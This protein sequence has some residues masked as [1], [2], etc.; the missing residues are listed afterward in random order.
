MPEIVLQP[1]A[2]AG[3]DTYINE[4]SAANNFGTNIA[5]KVGFIGNNNQDGH[6]KF[7]LSAIAKGSKIQEAILSLYVHGNISLSFDRTIARVLPANIDWTE[8]GA[9]WNLLDGANPW[10]GGAGGEEAGV[11]YDAGLLFNDAGPWVNAAFNDFSL[12]A[13]GVQ[14]MVDSGNAGFKV[15]STTRA[16]G[17]NRQVDISSSDHGTAGQRPKL[18]VRWI[19]PSGRLFEYKV[20]KF[21]A[22]PTVLDPTG[23]E[24][25]LNEVRPDKW[26]FIEGFDLPSGV[27]YDSLIPDPRMSYGVGVTFDEDGNKLAVE[28]DRN[29][30]ADAIIQRLTRGV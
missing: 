8:G 17:V 13:S 18:F 24:V 4:A 25:P 28:A 2:A 19:E 26:W 23:N 29:Q 30:F 5:I 9:T 1:G 3:V 22:V 15:F 11:D 7:D 6:I 27:A 21:D 16:A 12:A 10:A 20:N 14:A